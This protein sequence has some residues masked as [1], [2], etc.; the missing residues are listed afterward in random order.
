MVG[1]NKVT[2]LKEIPFI[3]VLELTLSQD[4]FVRSLCRNQS[5]KILAWEQI[6]PDFKEN[7]LALFEIL[8]KHKE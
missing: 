5:S 7:D 6:K 8:S 2:K 3:L 4:F 1:N